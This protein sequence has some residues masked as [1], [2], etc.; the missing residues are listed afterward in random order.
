MAGEYEVESK[1]NKSYSII[2]RKIVELLSENSRLSV[3]EMAK[4]LGVSRPTISEK[5]TRLENELGLR[6]TLELNEAAL[7][8][9]SPHII[10][11]TFKK[12]PNFT[13]IK[14]ILMKSYIPQVVF[15]V[16]GDYDMVIYANALSGGEYAHW[17]KAMRILLGEFRAVWEPSEVIH[18]QLCFF[19]LRNEIIGRANLDKNSKLMLQSL[20]ENAR[21]SFQQ[22]SKKLNMHFNTVKYNFDKLAKQGLIMRPTITMNLIKNISFMSWFSNYSPTKGYEES[23]ARA[24]LPLFTDDENP[25][26][27]RY[28]LTASLIGSHDLFSIDVFDNKAAALKYDISYHKNLFV[29]HGIRLAYGEIKDVLIGRLPIRSVNVRKEWKRITWTTELGE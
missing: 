3:A 8:L 11:V 28:L 20:N 24:R 16:S 17:D 2:S 25:L 13:K 15:S 1:F 5:L 21:L 26:I 10:A 14:A 9:N 6:Y 12:K 7:G 23:S 27:N 4:Q 22:I 18:K 29:Q 19:P